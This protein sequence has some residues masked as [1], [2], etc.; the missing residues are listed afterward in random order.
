MEGSLTTKLQG[1]QSLNS[2]IQGGNGEVMV[3]RGCS[4]FGLERMH[5]MRMGEAVDM[6]AWVERIEAEVLRSTSSGQALTL[7][8]GTGEPSPEGGGEKR[9]EWVC[10]VVYGEEGLGVHHLRLYWRE[11]AQDGK[12]HRQEV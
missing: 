2:T 5:I 4:R 6:A 7:R 11:R 8:Q 12:E 10:G 9:L 1:T 3:E